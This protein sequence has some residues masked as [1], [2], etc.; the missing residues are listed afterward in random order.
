MRR[1]V[2]YFRSAPETNRWFAGDRHWRPI[3]R[4][5]A[6]GRP[7]I[8][9]VE[10]V[11]ANLCKGLDGLGEQYEVNLPFDRLRPDDRVAV[12]GRGRFSLAG[13]SQP[14]PIVAGIGLMSNPSDWPT[15]CDEY[16]VVRYL[17]H[18]R[19]AN[20]RYVPYFGSRCEVWPV[21][22][23]TDLWAPRGATRSIDLLIYDKLIRNRSFYERDLLGPIMKILD[24]RRITFKELRY[25]EY[26]EVEFS[27]L[28]SQSAA[29]L[30]LSEHESQGLA[31]LE[32]LSSGVP[33]LAWDQGRFFGGGDPRGEVLPTPATS[34]PYFD[35]SC[36]DLFKGAE[37][38]EAQLDRFFQRVRDSDL[39]PRSFVLKHLT[40][41]RCSGHFLDILHGAS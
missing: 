41:N 10:K 3:V 11:F 5:L 39:D 4:R 22:I 1:D 29:M 23:D 37:D 27:S 20:E 2:L 38:F 28:L 30:F 9:G 26:S 18:S 31:Y 6:R 7:R 25:G 24:R 35:H 17:Q 21:G 16:P 14:N 40:L 15:L 12:L 13:Y 33:V 19:W 34:V 36:G 32:C 8:G